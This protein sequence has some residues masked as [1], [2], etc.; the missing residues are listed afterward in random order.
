M[1][2]DVGT[3]V[4]DSVGTLVG[5]CVG[6]SVGTLVGTCVGNSVWTEDEGIDVKKV[7]GV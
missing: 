3:F 5:T 6:D 2:S 4:G 7:D 1:N